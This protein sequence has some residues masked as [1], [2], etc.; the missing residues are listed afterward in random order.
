MTDEEA[1]IAANQ[2]FYRAFRQ[3]DVAG[4]QA[5]WSSQHPVACTHPGWAP[6]A[7]REAVL[8]SFAA[9][10]ASPKSPPVRA[11]AETVLSLG[12]SA[13]VICAE[14]IDDVELTATNVFVREAGGWR[15]LVHHASPLS[16]QR[17]T[18][19]ATTL[20]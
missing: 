20:N 7:G 9:I 5:I 14:H 16:R 10:L 3:R 12:Q 4:M 18:P 6:L 15:L 13:V 17:P 8:R 11:N 1:I 2:E 19:P